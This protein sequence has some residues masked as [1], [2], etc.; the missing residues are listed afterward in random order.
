[1]G[2]ITVRVPATSANLGPGFDTLGCALCLY[3]TFTFEETGD[4][5]IVTGCDEQYSNENN[6][7]V[8]SYYAIL[9]RLNIKRPLGLKVHI[10]ADVPVC[11]GLGSSSTLLVA[12][13]M[14]ANHIHGDILSRDQIL[15]ICS[16]MEGH[17]DNV[18]P[19]ICG[20][21][22]ASVLRGGEPI[23]VR[24][25]VHP[26]VKFTAL[27]PNFET[28]TEEARAVL[29]PSVPRLDAVYTAGCLAVLLKGLEKADMKAIAA[30]ADDK[31]HQPYRIHMIDQY[32]KVR[33]TAL[34]L[35]CAGF[36]ISGSGSTCLCI[37]GDEAFPEKMKEA[38]KGFRND[39]KVYPLAVDMEGAKVIQEDK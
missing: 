23:T 33:D 13:A 28:S 35:G 12:G 15:A 25:D 18:A 5:L 4:K 36:V 30:A 39:W 26:G 21:I 31:L 8:V 22:V 3:N 19:A 38:L 9:D 17:P 24:Y 6:L 1:M 20:G 29:P 11:R 34:S 16:E 37:G 27:V 32:N 2:K 14:A 10:E 7:A